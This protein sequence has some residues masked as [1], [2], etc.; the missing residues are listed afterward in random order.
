MATL[1]NTIT[2]MKKLKQENKK[3]GDKK[4]GGSE[5][6]RTQIHS[7]LSDDK[8]TTYTVTCWTDNVSNLPTVGNTMT[9]TA[10]EG[11]TTENGYIVKL[12]LTESKTKKV[13]YEQALQMINGMPLPES[14]NPF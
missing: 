11:R 6:H 4:R 7:S 10:C 2:N 1:K 3:R 5:D 12:E 8:I 9:V 14:K 13:T